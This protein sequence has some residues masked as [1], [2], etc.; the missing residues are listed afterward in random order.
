MSHCAF[1]FAIL[2][3]FVVGVVSD[4]THAPRVRIPVPSHLLVALLAF[5]YFQ[6]YPLAIGH[7]DESHLL[8]AAKRIFQGQVI[9]EDFFSCLTPL[10]QYLFAGVYSLG[11]T[12]LLAARVTIALIEAVGCALLFQLVRRVTSLAEAALVTLIFA[13]VCIP[14]WPY[15]S[16]HWISTVLVLVVATVILAER[17]QASARA[18][19]LLAGVFAG[20][21]VCV[22]QQRGVFLALWLPLALVVLAP[23]HDRSARLRVLLTQIAWA[24]GGTSIVMLVVL[25][26]AAWMSSPE[27]VA[28]MILVYALKYYGPAK[29]I[30][31]AYVLPFANKHAHA[32]W[33]WLL[34]VSPLFVAGEGLLLAWQARSACDRGLLER[35]A[36]CLLALLMGLSVWY[37]PDYIHVSFVLPFLLIPGAMLLHRLRLSTTARVPG[38]R[39]AVT[40]ASLLLVLVVVRKSAANVRAARATAPVRLETGFGTVQ[41]DAPAARLFRAVRRHLVREPDGRRLLYSYPDDA[42]LYLVLPADDP[43]PYS[44]LAPWMFPPESVQ[45]VAE[46]L[47]ARVPGTVVVWA[48]AAR[49]ETPINTAIEEGYEVVEEVGA[50]SI[51]Y[52]RRESTALRSTGGVE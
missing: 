37:M 50:R 25:G 16:P 52:V 51:I 26:H 6:T 15:A 3:F 30:G 36:L 43:T 2:A 48:P 13:G 12:T 34:R 29:R 18:R 31:W 1:F 22:Q 19:P 17:W 23:C 14:T 4:R 44:I 33:P 27:R 11:G 35:G 46:I 9:Y 21:A 49:G 5:A 42:W 24:V 7:A 32:T 38:G 45:Q 47:R 40:V 8:Y 10:S 39:H 41:V 20:I 28:D